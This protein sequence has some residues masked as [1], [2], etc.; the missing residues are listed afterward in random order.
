MTFERLRTAGAEIRSAIQF[1]T[2]WPVAPTAAARSFGACAFPLVGVAL[3]LGAIAVDAALV[4][5]SPALRGIGIVIFWTLATGALHYDALADTLDGLGGQT[6][7]ERLH[8]MKDSSIGAFGVLG[9]IL[10]V[11][12][13]VTALSV[14]GGGQRIRALLLAPILG[15]WAIVLA[16]TRMPAA[17]PDGLGAAFAAQLRPGDV[18][19]AT[20]IPLLAIVA[21]GPGG[22][23]A[24][25]TAL[26]VA[27]GVRRLAA[28]RFGGI[29]GDV[30]GACGEMVETLVLAVLA[31][32][33]GG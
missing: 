28:N 26:A 7:E 29:T 11:A 27:A 10:A 32:G 6:L 2:V 31:A 18:A 16:A 13:K 30:L 21:A 33:K 19:L 3:G 4:S 8:H 23:A 22:V 20:I 12:T 25:V 5:T 1:L 9:L 24:L 14:L 17:R 15:R